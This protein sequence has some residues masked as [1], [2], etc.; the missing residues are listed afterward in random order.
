MAQRSGSGLRPPGTAANM[1]TVRK[2]SHGTC[3]VRFTDHDNER[4]SLYVGKFALRDA[5]AIASKVEHLV[6]RKV[7]GS[8]PERRHCLFANDQRVDGPVHRKAFR[9]GQHSRTA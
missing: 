3:E 9:E 6:S 1:A 4:R 5:A 8:D 2:R 7:Q